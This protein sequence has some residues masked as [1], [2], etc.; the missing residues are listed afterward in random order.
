MAGRAVCIGPRWG[1]FLI[2]KASGIFNYC[3]RGDGAVRGLWTLGR[4]HRRAGA[5]SAI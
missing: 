3:P 5:V 4:D 2:T 1:L